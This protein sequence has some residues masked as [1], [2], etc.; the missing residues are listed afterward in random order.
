MFTAALACLLAG[1]FPAQADPLRVTLAIGEEGVAYR[2]FSEA[3]IGRLQS[4]KYAVKIERPEDVVAGS[5]LH[6]AVGMRAATQLATK[7]IPTLNVFVPRTGY[8]RLQRE[9]ATRGAPRSAIYLDQPM[10]RQVALLVAALPDTRHV[11]VLYTAPPPEL[12]S[13]RALLAER[14]IRLHAQAVEGRQS[15][16]DALEKVLNESEVLFVLPDAEIYNPG[17]IRNILLTAYRK[18]VPLLGISPA[19]V[20]AGALCAVFST[21][22][23]VAAQA[24]AMIGRYAESGRLP[25]AQYPAEFEVS[26][27]MQVARSLDLRIKDTDTLC[28]EIRRVP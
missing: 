22:E 10:E 9:S 17:T 15:L 24:A 18:Q 21:P 5:G 25:A 23:Q 1:I 20:R 13:L 27:N 11:G 8:E 2:A 4:D 26:V 19:Y 7:D 16:N 3:L 14:N 12:A 28:N 6:I